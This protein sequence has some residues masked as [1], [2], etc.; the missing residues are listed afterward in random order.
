MKDEVLISL[1]A[2]G[3]IPGSLAAPSYSR[4]NVTMVYDF[5]DIQP[6][7]DLNWTPC[8]DNFTCSMLE[9]PL[10][11]A[12][13]SI[14]TTAIAFIKRPVS[15]TSAED[16]IFNPGGPG[17]SGIPLILGNADTLQ[18]IVGPQYNLVSFDPRGVNN[19]G[20]ELECFPDNAAARLNWELDR[21]NRP[22]D[23]T[24]R[25]RLYEAF[26]LAGGWGEWCTK[27]QPAGSTARYA[28][29]VAVAHDMLRFTQLQAQRRG[30]PASQAKIR[31]YGFSYGT[32][33]GATFASLFPDN[34]ER[35]ILDGTSD[36]DEYY[37][38]GWKNTLLDTDK[39]ANAFF[40]S[41]YDAGPERCVFHGNSSSADEIEQRFLQIYENLR[42]NPI[43]VADPSLSSEP[44]LLGWQE[45]KSVFMTKLYNA[46]QDF[47]ALA[48]ML[49]DLERGNGTSLAIASGRILLGL[50]VD[51]GA[52]SLYDVSQ[53]RTLIDCIDSNG[54]LNLSKFDQYADYVGFMTNI[55]FYGGQQWPAAVGGPC[56]NLDIRPPSSQIFSGLVSASNT[57]API[58][59]IGNTVDP[60][61]PLA[62]AMK[63]STQFPG[64]IVL[65]A[66][67]IGHTS[68][69]INSN[70]AWSYAQA[71][72]INGTLPAPGTLCRAEQV[73]F[74]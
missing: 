17:V 19:S 39:A 73:P 2:W 3:I 41:C 11:Y 22:V 13:L 33:L 71:Y 34:I 36:A 61:T 10:D 29:T 56:R 48:S 9:V 44:V 8:W 35:M 62:S 55:S 46:Q 7:P 5:R 24:T 66:E 42:K 23:D 25:E 45:L 6:S 12:D 53:T 65:T 18:T 20:I 68:F 64:S 72:L 47:P 1:L 14:G 57:S 37:A 59:F 21:L 54:R 27:T 31:Y 32:V 58:L 50:P 40:T 70:C 43:L 69:A 52:T 16:I 15:N 51:P 4:N 38:G 28:N 67:G 30:R 60:V 63:M 26:Q 74:F 49:D